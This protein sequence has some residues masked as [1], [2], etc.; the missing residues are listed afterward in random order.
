MEVVWVEEKPFQ[1]SMDLTKALYYKEDFGPVQFL[2]KNKL[3]KPRSL[4]ISKQ[5]DSRNQQKTLQEPYAIVPF[6]PK[7]E[8]V[9]ME[10]DN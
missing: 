8:L 3:G 5:E 10:V 6:R 2:G 4:T 9:I 7:Q 1:A